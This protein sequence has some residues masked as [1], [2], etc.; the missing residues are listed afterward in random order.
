MIRKFYLLFLAAALA[1]PSLYAQSELK[2]MFSNLAGMAPV[3]SASD[4][5]IPLSS[6]P[7]V[8]EGIVTMKKSSSFAFYSGEIDSEDFTRY[9]AAYYATI[10]FKDEA[11]TWPDD[12]EEAEGATLVINSENKMIN[13][14]IASFSE[15]KDQTAPVKVTVDLN[16]KT[17]R[18][19]QQEIY[20]V[21]VAMYLWGSVDGGQKYSMMAEMLPTESDPELFETELDVPDVPKFEIDDPEFGPADGDPD[22]GFLFFLCTS[23]ESMTAGQIYN[24]PYEEKVIELSG[25]SDIFTTTLLKATGAMIYD[26]T[27]GATI[28]K[29]NYA[30]KQLD[31]S[32]VPSGDQTTIQD[33]AAP[34][35]GYVTVF[36]LQGVRVFSGNAADLG[37]IPEGVYIVNGKKIFLQN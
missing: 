31:V 16:S 5:A 8:Y 30:S 4:E 33:V 17:I 18:L 35:D 29:F 14:S 23:G 12:E 36:N 24:A 2:V 28:F 11:L 3:A 19:E 7:G 20:N 34:A 9:S 27:P 22:H 6:T 10:S 25:E 32:L 1:V 15:P 21:P 26:L 13:W 37:R